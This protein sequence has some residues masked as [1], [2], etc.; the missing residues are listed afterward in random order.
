MSDNDQIE[1]LRE[2]VLQQGIVISSLTLIIFKIAYNSDGVDFT[3]TI[4]SDEMGDLL[5]ETKLLTA[6][7]QS[8]FDG[9]DSGRG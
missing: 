6:K 4:S 9:D 7:T 2:L 5:K 1:K 8:L 3:K